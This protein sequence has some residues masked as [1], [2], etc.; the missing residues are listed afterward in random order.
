MEQCGHIGRLGE[1]AEAAAKVQ[2]AFVGMV[3][4]HGG[5]RRVVPPG[6]TEGRISTNPICLGAPTSTAPVVLD[7]GTSVAAEGK[8]RVALQKKE[9]LPD[10]WVVDHMGKPSNDPNV[11]YVEPRGNI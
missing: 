1:Y 11:L 2:M 5:G 9:R 7:F 4:S 8:I 3:N 10:G 6:G